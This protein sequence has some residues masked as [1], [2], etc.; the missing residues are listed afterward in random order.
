MAVLSFAAPTNSLVGDVWLAVL[1]HN[2]ADTVSAAPAGWTLLVS[3]GSVADALEV[4]A[5]MVDDS[6][7][8]SIDFTLASTT[9]EWQ[10]E[11][12]TLTGTSPGVMLESAASASFS[13]ATALTTAGATVQQAIDI[14]LVVWTCSGT[15]TLTLPAGFAAVDSFFTGVVTTRSMLVGYKFAG[16]TGP[17]TFAAAT[18]SSGT[19]GRSFTLVLRDQVPV[20]PVATALVDVV[21]GNIGLIAKDTRPPR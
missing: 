14:I 13:A 9:A 6:E 2:A 15:P 17:L 8:A 11:L 4:Y 18:A 5:H 20:T 16:A 19:T 12:I 1:A 3:L 7:P 21:P 10:G